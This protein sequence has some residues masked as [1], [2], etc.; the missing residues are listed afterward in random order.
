MIDAPSYSSCAVLL[1]AILFSACAVEVADDGSQEPA[2]EPVAEALFDGAP[3]AAVWLDDAARPVGEAYQPNANYRRN[4]AHVKRTGT[5]AYDVFL[6]TVLFPAPAM[7]IAYGDDNTRCKVAA[8]TT[9]PEDASLAIIKV[10][11]HLP[12]GAAANSR[13]VAWAKWPVSIASGRAAGGEV[14]SNGTSIFNFSTV[15]TVSPTRTSAGNYTIRLSNLGSGVHG[16][17]VQVNAFGTDTRH[18]KVVSWG[19]DPSDATVQTIDVRCFL[20][21]SDTAADSAFSFMYDEEIPAQHNRGAYSWANNA[22]SASYQPSPFYAL[23]RG[24]SVDAFSTSATASRI[25]GTTGH[26]KMVYHGL[27]EDMSSNAYVHVSAYGGGSEYCKIRNWSRANG[28]S[29]GCDIEVQTLCFDK[30]GN[31]KNTRYVQTWGSFLA[32]SPG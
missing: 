27:N 1:A 19:N 4:V 21:N 12:S 6:S 13:F 2:V 31:P 24:P 3:Q 22:T 29:T 17:T 28:C 8:T 10:K 25:A 26:Y 11:C 7:A 20:T 30:A 18:C 23:M 32:L 16:G 15:G 9:N 5:G 14:Q